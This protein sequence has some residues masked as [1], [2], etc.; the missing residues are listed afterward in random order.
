MDE[1]TIKTSKKKEIIDITDTVNGK[2]EGSGK[3]N[4]LCNI[5]ILHTTASIATAD[6]DP[7][8]DLDMLDAFDKIVPKL[9][10][11]HPHDPGH[12]P[13]H[14]ISTILGASLAVPFANKKLSL[15]E[16][17]KIVLIEMNGPRKRN[18]VLS[19]LEEK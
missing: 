7:G 8:T 1:I 5:F 18:I 12:V 2:I 15:G 9:I 13:D 4:G 16:W 19:L 14:I 11:R 6:L 3:E 17:Q 10:Y